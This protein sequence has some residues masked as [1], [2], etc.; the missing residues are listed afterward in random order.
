MSI[1]QSTI[2]PADVEVIFR[3]KNM[4]GLKGLIR[5][6]VEDIVHE[7]VPVYKDG[8]KIPAVSAKLHNGDSFVFVS[9][10]D[11]ID[12]HY[13]DGTSQSLKGFLDECDGTEVKEITYTDNVDGINVEDEM[14]D[15]YYDEY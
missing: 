15:E 6:T 9:V 10:L 1:I 12:I 8:N 7:G 5:S 11:D 14:D 13:V 4:K 2:K 3:D